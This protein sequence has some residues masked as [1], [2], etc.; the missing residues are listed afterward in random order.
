MTIEI[1]YSKMAADS[2]GQVDDPGTMCSKGLDVYDLG[3]GATLALNGCR[4]RV[5]PRLFHFAAENRL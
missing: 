5:V 4:G 3:H 2:T 1:A